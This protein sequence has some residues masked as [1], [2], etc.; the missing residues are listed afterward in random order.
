[1]IP[2][3]RPL[4][5]FAVVAVGVLALGAVA[6]AFTAAWPG[7]AASV[8]PHEPQPTLGGTPAEVVDILAANVAVLV[9]PFLFAGAA[10]GSPGPWRLAGDL[11]TIAILALN[12]LAVGAALALN[13][14]ELI[15]YLPH[16]PVEGA[17][18]AL[19]GSAWLSSR[20]SRMPHRRVVVLVVVLAVV[21]ALLEVYATPHAAR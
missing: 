11:V 2:R 8:F 1:M 10:G 14:S 5:A 7:P 13:G 16:L 3:G 12:S 9:V 15:R 19:T 21:A 6:A 4:R 20:N 17:A 18:L